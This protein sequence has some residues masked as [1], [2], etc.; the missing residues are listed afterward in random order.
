MEVL[1]LRVS[2]PRALKRPSAAASLP[3]RTK[4]GDVKREQEGSPAAVGA[5]TEMG[6]IRTIPQPGVQ[7]LTPH[8]ATDGLITETEDVEDIPATLALDFKRRICLGNKHRRRLRLEGPPADP[9]MR[10]HDQGFGALRTLQRIT[11]N[12][13]RSAE[14]CRNSWTH[15]QKAAW[16]TG[17]LIYFPAASRPSI[18]SQTKGV[19]MTKPMQATLTK[20]MKTN[21]MAMKPTKTKNNGTAMKPK[22]MKKIAANVGNANSLLVHKAAGMVRCANTGTTATQMRVNHPWH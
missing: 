6:E 21:G 17:M 8:S 4:L 18:A 3:L 13:R 2:G 20:P 12:C 5:T 16:E 19:T 15:G 11:E 7:P 14:G 22:P 10:N 1:Q 9:R